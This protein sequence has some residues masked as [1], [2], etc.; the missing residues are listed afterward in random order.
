MSEI[1]ELLKKDEYAIG[2]L[3]KHYSEPQSTHSREETILVKVAEQYARRR[4]LTTQQLDYVK[5]ILPL[6]VKDPNILPKPNQLPFSSNRD[7]EP[8][9]EK[10]DVAGRR[11]ITQ[12]A[13]LL[14]SGDLKIY[15]P[16]TK[17]NV[18]QL[19]TLL[20]HRYHGTYWTAMLC[21]ENI[22][23][24]KSWN[25][26]LD[27]ALLS[28]Y[29][30]KTKKYTSHVKS[31]P[32]LLKEPYPFQYEGVS[33][34]ESRQGRALLAD[35][36]G[37]GKTIQVLAWL[38]LHPEAR[39][40]LIVCPAS[41][42]YNWKYEAKA[43]MQRPRV[44]VLKGRKPFETNKDILIINYDIVQNWLPYLKKLPIKVLV[45]DEC[46][47][48]KSSSAKRTVAVRTLC[49]RVP[50]LIAI[51][52]T[53]IV[54]RPIE[55]YNII[56]FID[57]TLFPSRMTF[58]EKFCDLTHGNY[59]WDY[60]GSSNTEELH[61]ILTDTIMIRRL[62]KNVL[63]DL[64]MKTKTMVSIGMT[65]RRE[66]KKA[67][68]HFLEWL[69]DVDPNA[70][71]KAKKAEALTRIE[72]LKQLTFRGKFKLCCEWIDDFLATGEK[73]VL[74]TT[75]TKPLDLLQ[76]RYGDICSRVDGGVPVAQRQSIVRDFQNNSS[77]RLF[78]GQVKAAGVGLT[79][80][81]SSNVVFLE[82]PW[83]PGDLEQAEDRC[84]RIGQKE[85]VNVW[86]LV[87]RNTIEEDIV[88]LLSDKRK[89]LAEILD[90]APVS[91]SKDL[92]RELLERSRKRQ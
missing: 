81:A 76:K 1:L 57:P 44:R 78:L 21:I 19:K 29:E 43:W 84:H 91:A 35:E 24:L 22:N 48:V 31:V 71:T 4:F 45:L 8:Q 20:K 40:A 53:P 74:F 89:V 42:K 66:Y 10:E 17:Q 28:W 33:F 88:E 64:P 9:I 3:V 37:L 67:S 92:L 18:D 75:H 41:L 49:R 55:F 15:S 34:I 6:H 46:H 30:R 60:T 79:L 47:G 16:S 63:K 59:G 50:H 61:K 70:V 82:M 12:R 32:G 52:G 68:E 62:K 51:S 72:K 2:A 38:Q 83:T 90:G 87:A 14:I 7:I 56:N 86:Y 13:L 85:A 36:M 77:K 58:A 23:K 26:K 54:N 65:N 69:V 11:I 27:K 5:R 39:P 80:T 25:Y 73:L